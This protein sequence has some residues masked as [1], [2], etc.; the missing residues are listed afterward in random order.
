MLGIEEFET[1]MGY[2]CKCVYL[3]SYYTMKGRSIKV[4]FASKYFLYAVFSPIMY[5]DNPIMLPCLSY[6]SAQKWN[7]STIGVKGYGKSP[8][9]PF[10]KKNTAQ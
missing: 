5:K 1:V 10:I 8:I 6:V 2:A 9:A 3:K 4:L 7:Q